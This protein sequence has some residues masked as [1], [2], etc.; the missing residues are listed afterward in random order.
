MRLRNAL[1]GQNA[2]NKFGMSPT[3]DIQHGASM[4][5]MP[6]YQAYVSNTPYVRRNSFALL[7]EAPAG[8]QFLPN[9]EY[10]VG[11]LKSLLEQNH[12]SFEGLQST[13]NATYEE[14]PMGGAGEMMQAIG[15]MKRERSQPSYTF[16]EK[17]GRAI[18]KFHEGWMTGLLMDPETKIPT[19]MGNPRV[20]DRPADLLPDVVGATVLFIE[21]DPRGTKP[22]R[23]WLTTNMMPETSGEWTARRDITTGGEKQDYT[24]RY[25]G[26]TQQGEGVNR[27][28]ERLM[29][30][31]SY[32]GVNPNTR[33]AFMD[34]ISANVKAV[35]DSGYAEQINRAS[36]E[37]ISR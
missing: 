22:L 35:A 6:D 36:R 27:L 24:I 17:Y 14:T 13:L 8:F 33:P 34:K 37:S 1:A 7:L 3:I 21:P 19:V 12:L 4:G 16:N 20:G 26:L 23:A 18:F 25:T 28:A 5:F 32:S 9:P 2:W 11:A 15:D 30:D 29:D 10:W 31:I